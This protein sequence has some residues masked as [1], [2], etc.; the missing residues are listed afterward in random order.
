MSISEELLVCFSQVY[1]SCLDQPNRL[2]TRSVCVVVW[3]GR[4][5][6]AVPIPIAVF[7]F[8]FKRLRAEA[9]DLNTLHYFV[10]F[11]IS[12]EQGK[13]MSKGSRTN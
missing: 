4:S 6:M 5:V 11:I 12:S 9:L 1:N 13:T 2:S 10:V 8:H 3:E 7:L